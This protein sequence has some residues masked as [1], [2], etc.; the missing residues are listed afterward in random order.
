MGLV[1]GGVVC[2]MSVYS[3]M[4]TIVMMM[5]VGPLVV[6]AT[7]ELTFI[8]LPVSQPVPCACLK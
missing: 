8:P 7:E 4:I 3:L 2:E 1:C 6:M 5:I